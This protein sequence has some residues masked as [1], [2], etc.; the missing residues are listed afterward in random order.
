MPIYG[1]R[2]ALPRLCSRGREAWGFIPRHRFRGL[3]VSLSAV[4]GYPCH[5]WGSAPSGPAGWGPSQPRKLEGQVPGWSKRSNR[6]HLLSWEPSDAPADGFSRRVLPACREAG[7]PR[8]RVTARVTGALGGEGGARTSFAKNH[9]KGQGGCLR[10]DVVGGCVGTRWA[11][12]CGRGGPREEGAAYVS[13]PGRGPG[14]GGGGTGPRPARPPGAA[15]A[16]PAGGTPELLG[17]AARLRAGAR[18]RQNPPP[19]PSPTCERRAWLSVISIR[20]NKRRPLAGFIYIP[21][22]RIQ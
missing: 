17:P 13:A 15:P 21:A 5:A 2:S 12:G 22:R 1:P 4:R 14:D 3:P 8:E 19:H 7:R 16:R 20:T 11:C 6:L 9:T 18:T 10:G